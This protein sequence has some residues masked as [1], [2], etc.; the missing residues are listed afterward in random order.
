MWVLG[1]QIPDIVTFTMVFD[2]FLEIFLDFILGCS[3][4]SWKLMF[5]GL[6][7]TFFSRPGVILS[8]ET[9]PCC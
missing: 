3:Q 4:I 7:F 5:S 9:I 6:V 1:D 2:I 8:V